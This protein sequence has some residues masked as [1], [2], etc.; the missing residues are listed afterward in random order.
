MKVLGKIFI[1]GMLITAICLWAQGSPRLE[2]EIQ[3]QKVNLTAAEKTGADITYA[4]GDT[5]AYTVIAKNTG[6]GVMVD[7]SIVD[8]IPEGVSYVVDSAKGENCRIVFS[9]NGG[10]QYSV[11]PVMVT[12][13][14][15]GGTRVERPAE[16]EDVTHIKWLVRENIPAGGEKRL[17]FQVVVQ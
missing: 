11:W 8:P 7:P 4:P 3:E 12:A 17:S 2:I 10:M 14:T 1:I 6:D 16:T 13:T 9:V 15:E 5:I